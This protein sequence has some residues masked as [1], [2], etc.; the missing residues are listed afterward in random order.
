VLFAK[1]CRRNGI[2]HRPTA[3]ASPNQNGKAVA[4][5]A[6]LPPITSARREV[7]G[8]CARAFDV[9]TELTDL[10]GAGDARGGER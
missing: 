4:K 9:L 3:P 1:I 10:A 6:M 5:P 8:P 2:T 7:T